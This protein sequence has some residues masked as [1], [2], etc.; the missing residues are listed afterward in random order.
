VWAA[1]I[2]PAETRRLLLSDA[3]A[4]DGVGGSVMR[5]GAGVDLGRGVDASLLIELGT[6]DDARRLAGRIDRYLREARQSPQ[7]LVLGLVPFLAGVSV[8]HDGP[9]ARVTVKFDEAQ[10]ETLAERLVGLMRLAR[11]DRPGRAPR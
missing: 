10:T 11:S 5:L 9:N 8:R 2:V 4:S 7:A 1:A 3:G 6:E